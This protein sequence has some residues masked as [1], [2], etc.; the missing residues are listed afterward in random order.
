MRA[1]PRAPGV[2]DGVDRT[3]RR[4]YYRTLC[5]VTRHF[6]APESTE[7][8]DTDMVRDIAAARDAGTEVLER[9]VAARR[10]GGVASSPCPPC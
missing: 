6:L 1:E 10:A 7:G 5:E 3:P 4:V 9:A 2:L 8:N